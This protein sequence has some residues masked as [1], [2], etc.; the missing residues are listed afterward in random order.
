MT[1]DIKLELKIL[2]GICVIIMGIIIVL[3]LSVIRTHR[4][5]KHVPSIHKTDVAVIGKNTR[6]LKNFS[7][8]L[9]LSMC[10]M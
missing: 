7:S 3:T 10:Y 9:L 8:Y 2:I 4:H 6:I 1:K 5:N